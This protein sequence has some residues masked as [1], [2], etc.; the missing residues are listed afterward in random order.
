MWRSIPAPNLIIVSTNLS[1]VNCTLNKLTMGV[2]GVYI[3][4]GNLLL[5]L[6]VYLMLSNE[7]GFLGIVRAQLWYFASGYWLF[8][9][10][11]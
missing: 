5:V 7:L 2:S 3:H 8:E 10:R 1:L 11:I 4:T 9:G 6:E